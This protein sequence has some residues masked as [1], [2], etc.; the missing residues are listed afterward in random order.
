MHPSIFLFSILYHDATEHIILAMFQLNATIVAH[1]I[2]LMGNEHTRNRLY[3]DKNPP[4]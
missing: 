3:S 1:D 4:L 2:Y